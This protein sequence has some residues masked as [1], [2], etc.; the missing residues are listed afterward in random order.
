MNGG[1]FM[2]KKELSELYYLNREIEKL[3]KDLETLENSSYVGSSEITGLP[4]GNSKSDSVG[5]MAIEIAEIKEL[6]K[7]RKDESVLKRN[8]IF[9][10]INGIN[11]VYIRM[12]LSFRYINGFDWLQVAENIGGGNTA[13]SVRM[14]H[15]RFLNKKNKKK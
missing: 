3:S 15:N 13:D 8:K 14:A 9:R 6:I 7:L 4:R 5:K 1:E 12:I 11:D 10:Y 2:T